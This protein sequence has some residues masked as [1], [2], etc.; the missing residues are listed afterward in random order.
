MPGSK[1][2][3]VIQ[4]LGPRPILV[5]VRITSSCPANGSQLNARDVHDKEFTKKNLKKNFDK[6]KRHYGA[7]AEAANVE[8]IPCIVDIGGQMDD[9]FKKLIKKIL[10][11]ASEQRHIP[12]SVLWNYWFSVLTV[13]LYRGRAKSIL[14]LSKNAFGFNLPDNY[15][16]SDTVVSRSSYINRN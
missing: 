12:M 8:F 15:R 5:D 3:L 14:G 2:D 9:G 7:A 4:N 16:S 13:S 10:K 6:K 11:S 1:G